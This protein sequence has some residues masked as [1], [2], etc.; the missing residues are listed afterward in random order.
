VHQWVANQ[1][2][3]SQLTTRKKTVRS[4]GPA[5]H[6]SMPTAYLQRAGAVQQIEVGGSELQQLRA[7]GD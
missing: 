6:P 5:T 2:L 7:G 1:Q 3:T 4:S